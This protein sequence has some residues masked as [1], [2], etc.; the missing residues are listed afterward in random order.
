MKKTCLSMVFI[1]AAMLAAMQSLSLSGCA[2]TKDGPPAPPAKAVAGQ[3]GLQITS[4][5]PAAQA[6]FDEAL[7]F[8]Y[9][10]NHGAAERAYRKAAELDPN[11]A[12]AW[13]GVA[14]VNGPH[15]NFPMV[16]PGK[17]ATAWEALQ[18]AQALA[19]GADAREQA[20]I[21]AL[22]TRYANPQPE[23]RKALDE[24]YAAA[25]RGVYEAYPNDADIATLYAE[26]M[27][28]LRP[29]DLWTAEG[30]PQPGTELIA[31]TLEHAMDLDPAHPGANHYYIHT[32]EASREPG[33]AEAAADRLRDAAKTMP[34]GSTHL[35]H[36]PSHIYARVGRWQDA[37]DANAAAMVANKAYRAANPRPG[38]F[39]LYMTHNE[40]FFAYSAM[41]QGRSEEALE[42]A[43]AMVAAMPPEF[44]A[45]FAAVADGF[46]IFPSEVLMRFGKWEAIL[47]EPQPAEGLPLSRALWRF[48]RAV[49]LTALNRMDDAEKER[50]AFQEAVGKVPAD[51]TFGNNAASGILTVA[52]GVLDGEM[53]AQRGDY[54]QS[55]KRLEEAIAVEGKMRY[56]EPPD[57]I[58]P[59]RHTLGAVLLRAGQ[60]ADA[61]R[62]YREELAIN[63]E[64]GWSLFGLYRALHLQEKTDEAAR[65]KARFEKAWSQ[66]DIP[67][68]SSC[69]CQP[70]V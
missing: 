60:Y 51:W 11:C 65:M 36:M 54:A 12:M 6:A 47:E 18:K 2:T 20:L 46:M 58:Q 63:P 42:A 62:V 59:V 24:A 23:D 44:V 69:L 30:Q 57:W 19:P 22:A 35:V 34:P 21:G 49:A 37:A 32:V 64:N 26:S 27:M 52:S 66:S 31:A 39:A 55:V 50:Q 40:H 13:W 28:D 3:S 9:A 4:K 48:T 25:M 29:W 17:A 7:T 16:P 10:F 56:D 70:G 38:F 5:S 67:M 33:R 41:M 1:F 15:I 53:A 8:T 61:E 68:V 14:L 45:D 43:R